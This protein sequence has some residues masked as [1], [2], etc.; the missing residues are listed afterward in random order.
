M[1][2]GI[3]VY[4]SQFVEYVVFVIVEGINVNEVKCFGQDFDIMFYFVQV[5]GLRVGCV[6]CFYV[7]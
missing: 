1:F 2:S 4:M 7:Y 6:Q 5:I 3:V